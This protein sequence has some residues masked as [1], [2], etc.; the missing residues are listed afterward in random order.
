M[1]RTSIARD[2]ASKYRNFDQTLL[3]WFKWARSHGNTTNVETFRS[4][5]WE[6]LARSRQ[7][8]IVSKCWWADQRETWHWASAS[9]WRSSKS[10]IWENVNE[11]IETH[12]GKF[13]NRWYIQCW[14]K[15]FSGN[16]TKHYFKG[17]PY[18]GG[19]K[20]NLVWQ[21]SL[22]HQLRARNRHQSW[23]GKLENPDCFKHKVLPEAV[24]YKWPKSFE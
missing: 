4:K 1:R 19:T 13:H 17:D 8:S 2:S 21:C 14:L 6:L 22:E 12:H 9:E 24:T 3:N 11:S 16:P 23:S 20:R 5:A 10:F 15:V 7:K 18:S